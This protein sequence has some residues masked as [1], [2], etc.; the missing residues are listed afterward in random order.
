MINFITGL[1]FLV[2][3]LPPQNINNCSEFNKFHPVRSDIMLQ[4]VLKSYGYY[5]GKIDG[6]FGSNSKNALLKFQSSNNID[7]DGIVGT[8]ICT[9]FLDKNSIVKNIPSKSNNVDVQV[10]NSNQNYSQDL[11]DAQIILKDLGLY[12]STIDGIN[13]PSTKKALKSFQTKAGLVS[14]GVLG[15]LTISALE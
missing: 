8:E 2:S 5:D 14:D 10:K 1:I 11:Y 13:G 15:P 7:A 4:I 3:L 9:L 6:E 12:T